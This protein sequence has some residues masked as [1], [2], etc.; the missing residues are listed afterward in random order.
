[1]AGDLL[2]LRWGKHHGTDLDSTMKTLH[3]FGHSWRYVLSC[4]NDLIFSV[5]KGLSILCSFL[6]LLRD[7]L[8]LHLLSG[9]KC[10][11]HDLLNISSTA[12]ATH[13]DLLF[14]LIT[15]AHRFDNHSVPVVQLTQPPDLLVLL[16]TCQ[17]A[18]LPDLF[19]LTLKRALL[20]LAVSS[21]VHQLSTH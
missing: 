14:G 4:V 20:T 5:P 3:T 10:G 18:L 9:S 19:Q 12:S 8:G 16:G 17:T 7:T 2:L 6:P 11:T 1:M 21:Q 15:S 13:F